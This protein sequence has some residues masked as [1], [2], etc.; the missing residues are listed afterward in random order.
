MTTKVPQESISEKIQLLSSFQVDIRCWFDEKYDQSEAEAIRSRINRNVR[1]VCN[2]VTETGCLK[3]MTVAPPAAIGG[4]MI[5]NANPFDSVLET[6]YGLS[7]IPSIVDMLDESIG[8][9]EAN[10]PQ[11]I[12]EPTGWTRVDR[13]IDKIIQALAQA[14][15]EEDYQTIGLL[16][17]EAIISLAQ[18]VYDPAFHPPLDEVKPSETDAKRMLESYITAEL[19]GSSNEVLRKYAKDAYQLAVTVQHKRSANFREAALCVEATRSLT[20]TIAIISGQRNP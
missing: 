9:L 12:I 6:Y 10:K 16:C 8:V 19:S 2:I 4:L 13:N 11:Q 3:L 14:N 20:N 15:S 7:F 1:R 18:A 5:S 17:R